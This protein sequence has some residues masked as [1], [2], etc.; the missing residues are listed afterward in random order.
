MNDVKTEFA[1]RLSAAMQAAGY[2]AKPSVLERDFNQRYWGRSMTLHGV[3]RWLQGETLPSA[4]KVRVLAEWLGVLP[5]ELHYGVDIVQKVKDK[6]ER[7]ETVGYQERDL[8][9]VFLSL[10]PPQRKVVREVILAFAK[11]Y[12]PNQKGQTRSV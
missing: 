9:E 1:Q 3:R 6:K 10:D 2:E 8:F 5:H 4:D 12:S 11:A 7:W